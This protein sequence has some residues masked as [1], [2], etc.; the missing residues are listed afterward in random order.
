MQEQGQDYFLAMTSTSLRNVLPKG[1][2]S[3]WVHYRTADIETCR[4]NPL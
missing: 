4:G 1:R 3:R 2:Q